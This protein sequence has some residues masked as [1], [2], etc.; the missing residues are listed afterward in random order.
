MRGFCDKDKNCSNFS[1]NPLLSFGTT[2][3]L[4]E[5]V[6]RKKKKKPKTKQKKKLIFL[7]RKDF[8][9]QHERYEHKISLQENIRFR[10]NENLGSWESL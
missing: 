1:F 5:K 2:I 9:F 3:L 10:G 8:N 4:F 7:I 6:K